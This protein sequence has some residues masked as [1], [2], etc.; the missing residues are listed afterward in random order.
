MKSY[1]NPSISNAR[2]LAHLKKLAR[3]G[4]KA[5]REQREAK[6]RRDLES[7]HRWSKREKAKRL[8]VWEELEARLLAEAA[9]ENASTDTRILTTH[10]G[11]DDRQRHADGSGERVRS[12]EVSGDGPVRDRGEAEG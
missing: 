2:K 1:R 10:A 7:W 4:G 9:E 3:L 11:D 6:K 12:P 8:Q 5:V